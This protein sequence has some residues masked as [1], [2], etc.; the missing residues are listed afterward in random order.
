VLHQ[1][2]QGQL[3]LP[4]Q[5]AFEVAELS[6]QLHGAL[7]RVETP[8]RQADESRAN[9]APADVVGIDR[10]PGHGR[11]KA[12]CTARVVK[13]LGHQSERFYALDDGPFEEVL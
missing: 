1:H 4:G 12:R 10:G 8:A 3:E 2:Q 6:G 13:D 9:A 7:W 5:R 11:T